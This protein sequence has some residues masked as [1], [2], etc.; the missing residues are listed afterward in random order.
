MSYIVYRDWETK[1]YGLDDSVVRLLAYRPNPDRIANWII[2]GVPFSPSRG[3]SEALE[4]LIK[5]HKSGGTIKK[6]GL[7]IALNPF[8]N[9]VANPCFY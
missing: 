8:K 9:T 4:E 6:D 2:D 3:K 7:R 1:E 5:T